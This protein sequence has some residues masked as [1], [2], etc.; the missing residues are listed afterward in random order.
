MKEWEGEIEKKLNDINKEMIYLYERP[1]FEIRFD[2][3]K[4]YTGDVYI[5]AYDKD[6]RDKSSIVRFDKE[7]NIKEIYEEASKEQAQ[8]YGVNKKDIS[9]YG[10]CFTSKKIDGTVTHIYYWNKKSLFRMDIADKSSRTYML[11]ERKKHTKE[12]SIFFDKLD[13]VSAI[14]F[15]EKD[16]KGYYVSFFYDTEEEGLALSNNYNLYRDN[17]F[18]L[19]NVE[20]LNELS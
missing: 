11:E 8:E 3:N 19:E 7:F 15:K 17:L 5:Y 4:K 13:A 12:T 16:N 1:I 2:K 14:Y 10:I 18:N 9:S 20:E 6:D